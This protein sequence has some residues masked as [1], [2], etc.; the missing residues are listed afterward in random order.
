MTLYGQP[1]II[2]N[3]C[4]WLHINYKY[5]FFSGEQWMCERGQAVFLQLYTKPLKC[6]LAIFN[7]GRGQFSTKSTRKHTHKKTKECPELWQTV[8]NKMRLLS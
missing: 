4:E 5:C 3:Q 1:K 8:I 7:E 2:G 6:Y